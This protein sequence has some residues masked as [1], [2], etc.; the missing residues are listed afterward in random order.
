MVLGLGL[1]YMGLDQVELLMDL[2]A[3][4]QVGMGLAHLGPD[5]VV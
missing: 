5:W 3:L 2:V 4:E 1:V